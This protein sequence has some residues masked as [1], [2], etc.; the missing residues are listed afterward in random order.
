M[1]LEVNIA[2]GKRK[3]PITRNNK[4]FG[5]EDFPKISTLK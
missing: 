3:V 1:A 4:F 5:A 2:N